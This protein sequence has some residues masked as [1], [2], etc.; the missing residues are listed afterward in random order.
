MWRMTA[1]SSIL[2]AGWWRW[3]VWAHALPGMCTRRWKARR[4]QNAR[5]RDLMEVW[6]RVGLHSATLQN[7]LLQPWSAK[8]RLEPESDLSVLERPSAAVD[9]Q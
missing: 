9:F 2:R 6:K 5:K 7:A 8:E 4:Q 1:S 3:R